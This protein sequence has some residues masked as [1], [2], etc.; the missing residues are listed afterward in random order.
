MLNYIKSLK[1]QYNLLIKIAK[2]KKDYT[3]LT[4]F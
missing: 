3:Y 2:K 1:E 4:I